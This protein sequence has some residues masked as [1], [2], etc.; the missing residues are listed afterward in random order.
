MLFDSVPKVL[1]YNM[2]ESVIQL[3]AKDLQSDLEKHL[4]GIVD[5]TSIQMIASGLYSTN[6]LKG[7]PYL[8]QKFLKGRK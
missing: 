6:P 5:L 3:S 2:K 7:I 8:Y 4:A 1:K